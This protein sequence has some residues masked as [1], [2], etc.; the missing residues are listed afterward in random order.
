MKT[1]EKLADRLIRLT[2]EESEKLGLII[3]AKLMPEQA[4]QQQG[5]LQQQQGMNPQQQ[6]QMAMMG[7]RPGGSMPM[8]N[9]R[10]AAQQ[11]LLR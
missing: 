11:G 2:P 3:K 8:P 1:L 10:M 4:K 6:Q 5:L 7:K 9:S